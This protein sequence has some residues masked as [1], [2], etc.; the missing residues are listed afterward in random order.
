MAKP[1]N[2]ELKRVNINLPLST[3]E[4]VKDYADSLGIN[5]TSAYIVLLNQALDQK[6]IMNNLPLMFTMINELQ[7]LDN[8]KPQLDNTDI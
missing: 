6:D 8:V 5:T 1:K 7:K 4:K 2:T 3:I